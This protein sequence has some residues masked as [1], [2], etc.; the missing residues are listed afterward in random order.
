MGDDLEVDDGSHSRVGVGV[1]V[2]DVTTNVSM[3]SSP[4]SPR[5]PA[6]PIARGFPAGPS[7]DWR[8][9]L[10]PVPRAQMPLDR[11]ERCLERRP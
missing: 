11:G 4:A 1:P 7:Y 5:A 2:G 8:S 9:H 6:P 3:S 10:P